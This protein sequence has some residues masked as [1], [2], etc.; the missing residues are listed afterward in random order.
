[1]AIKVNGTTVIDD[2]RNISNVGTVTATSFSGNGSA[3]TSIDSGGTT[4]LGTM[5]TASGSSVT[6]SGL[7]LTGYK[8]VVFVGNAVSCN[9][10]GMR[11][12]IGA[13]RIQDISYGNRF[14]FFRA[15]LDLTTGVH[16]AMGASV[17]EGGTAEANY[18]NSFFPMAGQS[19]Y[20]NASTSLTVSLG[21]NAFNAGSINVYGVA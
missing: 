1:M 6:L 4:L 19:G 14:F 7:N 18:Y 5:S 3:L 2:S 8:T 17:Y 10:T 20:S 13:G 11:M 12:F 21:A 15:H 16:N 9:F